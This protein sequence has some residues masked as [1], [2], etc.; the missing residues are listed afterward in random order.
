[1]IDNDLLRRVADAVALPLAG[2]LAEAMTHWLPEYEIDNI[3]RQAIFLAQAAHETDGFKTL[4]EYATGTAY[5]GRADLGNA[6]PGDG[7][8]FKGRGI[9][10][11]TGRANYRAAGDRLGVELELHPEIVAEPDVAVRTACDFWVAHNLSA[12]ADHRDFMRV[13]RI[14]N[15]GYNGL[16]QRFVYWARA[17]RALGES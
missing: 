4:E 15:G 13:T 2:R 6:E 8:R 10:M 7:A 9:F 16:V 5:E 3:D 14:V 11:L 17:W 1:M 12:F